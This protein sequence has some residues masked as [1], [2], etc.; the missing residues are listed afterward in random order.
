MAADDPA[1][2]AAK[3]AEYLDA[4]GA[5]TTWIEITS[6]S[7]N[8]ND[9]AIVALIQQQSGL[10]FCSGTRSRVLS[11]L[12]PNGVESLSLSAIRQVLRNG[13]SVASDSASMVVMVLR[14]FLSKIVLKIYPDKCILLEQG[15]RPRDFNWIV[16]RRNS[17]NYQRYHQQR[18]WSRVVRRTLFARRA[19]QRSGQ[20]RSC[21]PPTVQH[22]IAANR[23]KERDLHRWQQ[24]I[25]S[26]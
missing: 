22:S 7:G 5:S 4:R 3:F 13:G 20:G 19:V 17:P 10:F 25:N 15:R 23:Y 24:C 26:N 1:A 21:H 6:T 2:E 14:F 11:A 18:R 8:A 9:P 12:K 16:V